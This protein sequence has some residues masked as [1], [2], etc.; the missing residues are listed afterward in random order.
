MLARRLLLRGGGS[1]TPPPPPANLDLT[2]SPDGT[3]TSPQFPKAFGYG[4]KTYFVWNNTTSGDEKV[5]QV[6]NATGAVTSHVLNAALES[7][8][9]SSPAV[10]VRSSDRRVLTAVTKHDGPHIGF[11]ISTNPEDIS[12]F[13]A[14]QSV[15]SAGDY[16][17]PM[18]VE[19]AGG[20]I[21]LVY[22]NFAGG[23]GRIAYVKSATG[24]SPGSWS[25]ETLLYTGPSG[26][27]PYWR[28]ATDWDRYIHFIA[29]D[30]EPGTADNVGH[31]YLDGTTDKLYQSDGTEITASKP[32]AFADI[33]LVKSG[34]AGTLAVQ[35][36]C[37]DGS[38]NPSCAL[39]QQTGGTTL[40][41]RN[42]RWNG[43]S[44]DDVEVTT[45]TWFTANHFLPTIALHP[46]NPDLMYVPKPV[47]G[48]YEIFRYTRSG[49][50]WSGVQLTSGSTADNFWPEFASGS[51]SIEAIWQKGT[52]T[53]DLDVA[54]GISARRT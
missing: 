30:V 44:W 23:T 14:E 28:I 36:V 6:V 19:L 12:A 2:A 53:S 45:T 29:T 46:R 41:C 18:L 50:V 17:Y 32:F 51:G 16:T 9:H 43:S 39:E 25:G 1:F 52:Y 24:G 40:S 4:G 38:G 47:S 27:V 15:L 22:R 10:L 35:A 26:H 21:Y 13:D 7:D 49:G 48:Y 3:W 5:G 42:V 54:A 11:Q 33:T 31:F 8:N 20:V 34:A 37:V